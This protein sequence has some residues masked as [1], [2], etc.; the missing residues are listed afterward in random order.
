VDLQ[1]IDRRNSGLAQDRREW[2]ALDADGLSAGG[3]RKPLVEMRAA[4]V[5]IVDDQ[6]DLALAVGDRDCHHTDLEA[7][8]GPQVELEPVDDTGLRLRCQDSR[9]RPA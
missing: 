2:L 7:R 8:I 4:A 6:L 5:A 3:L 1:G 9:L